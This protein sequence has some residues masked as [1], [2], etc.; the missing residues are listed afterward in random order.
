MIL[1]IFSVAAISAADL[2]DTHVN[3]TSCDDS[4]TVD[5][6][7][8]INDCENAALDIE[9]Q[10]TLNANTNIEGPTI[11]ITPPKINGPPCINPDIKGPVITIGPGTFDNL[12]VEINKAPAGSVLHLY[13]D[14]NGHYGSRIQFNKDLTIDGH[15]HILNCL[16]QGGCS[17]FYSSSGNIILKNLK[18]INAHNDYTDKGGAIYITGSAQYALENCT[19]YNNY[20]DDYGGA[21][22]NDVNKVLT[23]KNCEFKSNNADD[24]HGGAIFSKGKVYVENSTFDS[25]T[26]DENG[27]AIYS[28]STVEVKGSTFTNNKA[29]TRDWTFY[30]YIYHWMDNPNCYGGA[31]YS[32]GLVLIDNCTFK[33]NHADDYAGAIYGQNVKIN[34]NQDPN[35]PFNTFFINNE[36]S[37]DD[38]GAIYAVD[39]VDIFNTILKG[40]HAKVDGGAIFCKGDVNIGNCLFESNKAEGAVSQC[41]GGAIRSKETVIIENSTFKNNYAE[42]YGGAIYAKNIKINMNQNKNMALNTFF[43]G[44]SAGDDK[45]GAMYV[46]GNINLYNTELKGNSAKVDGGAIFCE[47]NVNLANCWFQSNKVKGASSQCYGG[48]IRAKETVTIENSTFKSNYA[49]DYGGAIYAKYIKIN[50]DQ[51]MYQS[52]NSFFFDNLA[53]D[54]QGGGLYA[55]EDI[56]VKNAEFSGNVAMDDG[57]AMYAEGDV[58]ASHCIFNNNSAL[59]GG[60]GGAI[61]S[62]K[63]ASVENSTFVGNFAD[64]LGPAIFS[65]KDIKINQK[66]ETT[67]YLCYFIKNKTG[68]KTCVDQ[69]YHDKDHGELYMRNVVIKDQ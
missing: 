12:Q 27:G 52:T 29:R 10:N 57:G 11:N 9:D 41:Y 34:M 68:G 4:L 39:K 32:T 8:K 26:A 31:I 58:D 2:N 16:N 63:G 15:G 53:D 54:N 20:A 44:N 21:I 67:S 55:T 48:A 42:D 66:S 25:N 7:I 40:N 38:G 61:Y 24:V 14:Y 51:S 3:E 60:K 28:T 1:L 59:D 30:E 46:E 56:I 5:D 22:Y 50:A 13:M 65:I 49:E 47:N 33:N 17:A 45:G 62:N 35:A 18:I 23:I 64:G 69:F 37:D 43:T 6:T 19:F 36:G